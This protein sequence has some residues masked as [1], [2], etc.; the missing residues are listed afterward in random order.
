M[1]LAVSFEESL[2]RVE[3]SMDSDGLGSFMWLPE[4][5]IRFKMEVGVGERSCDFF[6]DHRNKLAMMKSSCVEL[7]LPRMQHS[8]VER[9]VDLDWGFDPVSATVFIF[10]IVLAIQAF[11]LPSA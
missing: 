4:E 3:F 5:S 2:R 8:F 9:N 7:L 11:S 6:P 10:P 1:K